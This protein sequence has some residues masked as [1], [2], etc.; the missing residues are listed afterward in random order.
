LLFLTSTTVCFAGSLR[1]S[2]S[3]RVDQSE[4]INRRASKENIKT[5]YTGE[6]FS[7]TEAKND[8]VLNAWQRFKLWLAKKIA[9]FFQIE[10]PQGSMKIVELLL[11]II[12]I[13]LIIFVIYKIVMAYMNK[14]GNW[15]FGR[16]SD[17]L[18]I[19]TIAIEDNIHHE[20]FETLIKEATQKKDYRLA[21]RYYYL[22]ALKHL[23]EKNMIAWDHEKTNYDYYQEIE[24]TTLKNRFQ[25]ISYIYN[26][27]WYGE[28]DIDINEFKTGEK[29]FQKLIKSL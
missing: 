2:D 12:G 4:T 15:I 29:S 22:F 1:I 13:L 21:I 6:A 7:Y 24:N 16:K 25:Y 23:S 27:C 9:Q 17:K 28:F 3:L 19:N 18:N 11:K 5:R 8:E 20:N 26:Y 10:T 14:D